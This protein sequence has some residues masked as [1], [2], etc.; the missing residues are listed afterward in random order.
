M[1]LLVYLRTLVTDALYELEDVVIR[2]LTVQEMKKTARRIFEKY[3]LPGFA[4]AVDGLLVC[5]DG[6]PH[7]IPVGPCFPN[8]QNFFTR[9]MFYGINTMVVAYDFKLIVA[10]NED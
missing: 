3:H 5:C 1:G 10:L 8:R 7:G 2:L 4:Y 6:A 9:K